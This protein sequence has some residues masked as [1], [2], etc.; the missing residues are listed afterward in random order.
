MSKKIVFAIDTNTAGGG[1]RVIATLANYMSE[2]GYE[3]YLINSDSSSSFYPISDKVEIIKMCLD[4]E[5]TGRI[6]RFIKKYSFLKRFFKEKR[7][8][9]VISFL[10]NMEAPVIL[11]GLSTKTR[12][13]TSV[14]N[15]AWAYSKKERIF[16]RFFYPKIAGVVFQSKQVQQYEDF[17]KLKNSTV[18]MNP[19]ADD[20]T[21]AIQPIPYIDRRN[22]II[23][24]ARLEKQKNHEMLIRAFSKIADEFPEYELH[25]FGEG[26]QRE[27]LQNQIQE[28]KL[29]DRVFLKG[30]VA[31]AIQM[32]RDAKLFVMASNYEGFPNALAEALVY[33]IPSISTDFD[34]GVASELICEGENGW[35][36]D[37]G[38]V[39]GLS[40]KIKQV[41]MMKDETDIVTHKCVKAFEILNAK[42]VCEIWERFVLP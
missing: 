26:S 5:K 21:E 14:R 9:A 20:V 16:R 42:S 11:A 8:D 10:F 17:K 4:R 39:D 35:L 13:F 32:N 15:A 3:T 30:A 31:G 24:V 12:V 23:S 7:P 25:I 34:T 38:D 40:N 28:L 2:K 6:Q 37:V 27:Y 33:G 19:M 41:L 18:I 22:V 29:N 1:E 36:V